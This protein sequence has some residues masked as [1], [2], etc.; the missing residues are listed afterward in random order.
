VFGC[1]PNGFAN[2]DLRALTAELRGLDPDATTTGQTTYDPRRLRSRD[3]IT[4]IPGTHRYQLTDHGLDTAKFRT[5][6]HDRILPTP[7]WPNSALPRP[8]RAHSK[9]PPMPTFGGRSH[10]VLPGATIV[11]PRAS[12]AS[13]R[14]LS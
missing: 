3:M 2:K 13:L 7:A 9:Q 1:Q 6:I 12:A 14:R 5:T 4:R 11:I 10:G 8:H